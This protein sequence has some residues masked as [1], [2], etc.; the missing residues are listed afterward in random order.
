LTRERLEE[1]AARVRKGAVGKVQ[2]VIGR[3]LQDWLLLPTDWNWRLEPGLGGEEAAEGGDNVC[4]SCGNPV[5]PG[6][7]L[8]P[9]CKNPLS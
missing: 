9:E 3:Y 4:P 2:E 5:K 6:W 7:F 8:C 1:A